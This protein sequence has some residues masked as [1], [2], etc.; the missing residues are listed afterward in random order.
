MKKLWLWIA[1]GGALFIGLLTYSMLGLRRNR[2]EVCVEFNGRTNC[3]VASGQTP[4][5][6][7]RT[8]T[9]NACALIASGVTDTINCERKT[10]VSVRWLDK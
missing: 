7:Q 3:R 6:A 4:E 5:L 9:Q 2:V 10:P 8:A 1:L